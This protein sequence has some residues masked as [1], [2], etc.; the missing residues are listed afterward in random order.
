MEAEEVTTYQHLQLS[1]FKNL[2]FWDYY[3]LMVKESLN[4]LYPLVKLDRVLRQRKDAIT[5]DNDIEYKRCRVQLY[6]KGVILRDI[7]KGSAI[8]TKKQYPCKE[9]DF[10]VAEIDAKFGGYGIV[11]QELTGAIV[12]S[13]YFLFEIDQKQLLPEFLQLVVKGDSFASQ[14]KATGSTNYAAIRPYH[15]LD[16]QIPLPDKAEQQKLV[17]EYLF[18]LRQVKSKRTQA[19]TS[20]INIEETLQKELELPKSVSKEKQRIFQLHSFK[21]IA[22]WGVDKILGIENYTSSKYKTTSFE[23]SPHLYIEIFRGKS[24]KY[25]SN[26]KHKILNQKCNRWN[27]IEIKHAKPVSDQW[28][29]SISKNILTQEGDILVNSTGEGTIGRASYVSA[30]FVSLLIDSHMLLLRVDQGYVMPEFIVFLINSKYGQSQ[31]DFLKSAKSTKQTELG[32]QNLLRIMFPIPTLAIQKNLV[33][34][35][36]ASQNRIGELKSTSNAEFRRAQ[37]EFEAAIFNID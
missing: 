21:D 27:R 11:P 30:A 26:G 24:P 9:N 34:E 20:Q 36:R 7:V 32:V 14:V 6:G 15:V 3:T 37:L 35:I 31:I 12:S 10:L 18:K 1:S 33:Q 4:S 28:F 2:S 17:D 5:I 8:K 29:S 22:F 25:D 19:E 16:Y 23:L 13:H